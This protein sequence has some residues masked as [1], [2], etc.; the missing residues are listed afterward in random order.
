MKRKSQGIN[1]TGRTTLLIITIVFF[2]LFAATAGSFAAIAI[3]GTSRGVNLYELALQHYLD[4][5]RIQGRRGTISDRNGNPIA[6]QMPS[7]TLFANLNPNHGSIVEDIEYTAERLSEVID[8]NAE[9]IAA[10]LSPEE[11]VSQVEFGPAGRRL[12]F[13]EREQI[14][15]LELPGLNFREEPIRFYPNGVFASHSIG[16]AVTTP[17]GIVGHMG[18]EADF[19]QKLSGTDGVYHF[20]RDR[21]GFIQPNQQRMY[22]QE[23]L[24]GFDV[25]LTID[26]GIQIFLESAI[27]DVLSDANINNVVAVVMDVRTGA[28]LAAASRPTFDPN[29]REIEDFQN[30]IMT[31][32]EPG[33]TFKTFTYAAAIEEGRYVGNQTFRSGRRNVYGITINDFD[34]DPRTLTFD[35]GFYISANSATIDILRYWVDHVTWM[36]YLEAFGFGSTTDFQL[37][38]EGAGLLPST[39]SPVNLYMSSFGQGISVTPLQLLQA[40]S[41]ITNDG[42]MVRPH[43][44][45]E[46]YDPN[47]REIIYQAEPVVTGNPISPET[48]R[49]MRDLMAGVVEDQEIGTG[50]RH[51]VLE[52]VRSG[53]KT[54]TAQVA[55]VDGGGYLPGVYVYNYIGF[56]PLEDPEIMMFIAIE[57][58]GGRYQTGHP[59]AGE[60]YRFVMNNSLR[61]L[62]LIPGS[63]AEPNATLP[64]FERVAVPNL[65]NLSIADALAYI[66]AAGLTPVVIGN[67]ERVF[68]QSPFPE[69]YALVDGK[70]FIQTEMEDR[71]PDFTGW[72]RSEVNQYEFLMEISIEFQGDGGI[73]VDQS[74]A[75]GERVRPGATL[76]ITLE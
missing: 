20:L 68:R 64:Q 28:I 40:T 16:Y 72:N 38:G 56:A 76:V 69:S 4:T 42:A 3:S 70:V 23:P 29:V 37:S 27:E 26:S 52:D 51:Y 33:S 50:R 48:A 2:I 73:A 7:Y 19:N 58:E 34:P 53:G 21:Y 9:Q 63:Q 62:G 54:G 25:T 14:N 12:L 17:E 18:I 57:M 74:I 65:A 32:F 41:A 36:G 49:Q 31:S 5:G 6:T 43:I 60:I 71:L 1:R 8:L 75:P 24:D 59:Y 35:Q 15:A 44:V 47:T 46:I 45:S 13:T 11:G 61:Y 55:D 39:D 30:A 22:I 67:G 66:E 10:F